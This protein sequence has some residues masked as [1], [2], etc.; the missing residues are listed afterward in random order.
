[1]PIESGTRLG[2]YE[3]LAPLGAGGMGEVYRARDT[4]LGREVA[5]KVLSPAL[6]GDAQ[7]MARFQREAQVL[8]SLNHPHIATVY[9]LEES[10]SVRALVMEL[11]EGPT[12]ADR[13]GQGRLPLEEAVGI[14]KQIAEALEAAHERGVVHRDLKPANVKLTRAGD[15]KVLDFGLAKTLDDE[16]GSSNITNSPTI[17]MAATRAGVILG[18][19]AYMPPEQAKGKPVD[20]R[21]DIWAFG[22]VL[23]EM[24]TG[25]QM[26]VG[27]TAP[28]TLASV[29]RDDPKW[30]TLTE[31]VPLHI[32]KLLRRCLD[33]DPKRRLRDIGEAR[34]ALE[35]KAEESAAVPAAATEAAP[36]W[37]ERIAWAVAG[38]AILAACVLG[39]LY[40]RQTPPEERV[41]RFTIEPPEKTRIHTFSISPDGR[42][43]AMAAT[44]D[45]TR[46]LWV[47]AL[48]TLQ[49]Q[50]LPGTDDAMYPFWS[51][52]SQYIA[53][54]TTRKL[55]KVAVSGGP[56]QALCD[57]SQGRSGT[58]NPD[59][60]IVFANN[61]GPLQRVPAVGGVPVPA[62]T[63]EKTAVQ[64][65]PIFLPDG[66]RF[67]Y[68][69]ST[70]G[71]K[72]G[73][74]LASLG[75]E[76][77]RRLLP[78]RSSFVYMPATPANKRCYLL[79]VREETVVA[80][81]FDA[82][83]M[84][85]A[86]DLFPAAEH[87]GFAVV[88]QFAPLSGSG[89]GTLVYQAG[90]LAAA[91]QIVWY[92]RSGKE[93]TK[94]GSPMAI[95]V[96]TLSPDEKTAA[97]SRSNLQTSNADIWLHELAR[98][99]ETRFTSDA[100]LN[101]GAVWSPNGRQILFHSNRGGAYQ[102]YLKDTSGAGKDEP[103]LS[104][105]STLGDF[106]DD[107]S[108][109]GKHIL[110]TRQA[111][112][113]GYD[114]WTAPAT[115]ERKP[116][117]FLQTDFNEVQGQFSPDGNWVAYASDESG[118]YEIYVRPFPP[119]PGRWKISV[120]GG[121]LPRWR[122]DGRELFYISPDR[123]MMAVSLK[124][125]AGADASVEAAVPEALFDS[126]I[127]PVQA[128]FNQWGYSVAADGRRFLVVTSHEDTAVTP[129]TVVTN[130][131]A[132]VKR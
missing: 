76:P 25:R 125:K 31:D 127:V 2:P 3:I 86:G 54:F 123:K 84:Q 128:G 116:V 96:I 75:G 59:G 102:L 48:D 21:A 85:P 9:G 23:F 74:Y 58:W 19:A 99:A 130:W 24:L 56:P 14:A 13:I 12:L 18:T 42:Y 65:F 126:H 98:G 15:V 101:H 108:R 30:Q 131:L 120:T 117:P 51:P 71:D 70:G 35:E 119:A 121:Q 77:E 44:L 46:H 69:Q 49:A 80:Q 112:K 50:L 33:K 60:G 45:G 92:D 83:T 43:V 57:A 37:P 89:N 95:A 106:A 39:F 94:V 66:R 17:T 124:M 29:M 8:A 63:G 91:N 32:R 27:E 55:K 22:V 26:F 111:G 68:L 47:R 103:L 78:D 107:W 97:F 41:E 100:S 105:A 10:G 110:F 122:H 34:I 67:L 113:T 11:V 38:L 61:N 90:N 62:T 1:M 115:G 109:D 87:I 5:L 129:L 16:M 118:R 88:Q 104:S 20:K 132:S 114:L 36:G 81:P 72:S 40:F 79:F 53:F 6:A 4:S 28:E 64:R 73:I 82:R 93:L 52:D 7:Y